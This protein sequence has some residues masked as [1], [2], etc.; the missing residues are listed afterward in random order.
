MATAN[1]LEAETHFATTST[2]SV[3]VPC[4]AARGTG[5]A[6][7]SC[8]HVYR[9]PKEN[10]VSQHPPH[11]QDHRHPGQPNPADIQKAL[12][13]AA[14]PT[15]REKLVEQARRNH[16]NTD[17]VDIVARLPDSNFDSPAAVEKA[18]ARIQ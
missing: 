2:P 10:T 5:Y 1:T 6:A 4:F 3:R 18:I 17:I 8:P 9:E 14:Y 12:N 11:S 15:T 13:G 16:A 7:H